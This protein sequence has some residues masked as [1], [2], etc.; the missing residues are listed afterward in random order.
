VPLLPEVDRSID[1]VSFHRMNWNG[2]DDEDVFRSRVIA[3]INLACVYTMHGRRVAEA[4]A[5]CT[6]ANQHNTRLTRCL[7]PSAQLS[8]DQW[9]K[10]MWCRVAIRRALV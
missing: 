5:H 6:G 4:M 2:M 9:R 1:I 3:Y 8:A 7:S 10:K